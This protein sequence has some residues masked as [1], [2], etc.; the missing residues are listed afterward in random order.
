MKKTKQ[1]FQLDWINL[2]PQVVITLVWIALVAT[3]YQSGTWLTGWDN[4]H[5]EFNFPLNLGRATSA[6]WQEYQGLGLQGG[7]GHASEFVRVLIL[8]LLS[9]IV[10][11]D[12]IR[13]VATLGMV[14]VGGL[15]IDQLMR[16]L[17][18]KQT[19]T[20]QIVASISAALFYM[21]NVGTVQNFYVPFDPF[22]WFFGMLPWLILILLDYLA[23]PNRKKA[24]NLFLVHVLASPLGYVQTV[25]VV[26]LTLVGSI[27]FVHNLRI[28]KKHFFSTLK[29]KAL[30]SMFTVILII[31]ANGFWF[32]PVV[33]FTLTNS[34]V[35]V[36]AKMNQLAT[37]EVFY[38]NKYRGQWSDVLLMK[39]FW[40]DLHDI[41]YQT[42]EFEYILQPW[43][44]HFEKQETLV[45][46]YSIVALAGVGAL[47][48][49]S[50]KLNWSF[51]LI[52]CLLVTI[53]MLKGENPPLGFIVT[54][55]RNDVPL[56][57][58]IF[59]NAFTKWVVVGSM[60]YSLFFGLGLAGV[61]ELLGRIH[62]KVLVP[63]GV[64]VLLL[65][66]GSVLYL[67]KPTF[68][69][70][71]IYPQMRRQIPKEYFDLFT[72]FRSQPKDRRILLMPIKSLWG[73]YFH[74][75]GYRGSGFIW[76]GIEQ[77]IVD[78]T[79][80]VWSSE[81]ETIYEEFNLAIQT[82][83]IESLKR[84]LQKY[85]I[86]YLFFDETMIQHQSDIFSPVFSTPDDMIQELGLQT[87][88]REGKLTVA[89]T[90]PLLGETTFVQTQDATVI[91]NT[92]T[93]H[94]KID[95]VYTS[96]G[97]YVS[98]HSSSSVDF[99]FGA[100][101]K[102]KL[103]DTFAVSYD[104]NQSLLS[105]QLQQPVPAQQNQ[106]IV[107][108]G[109]KDGETYTTLTSLHLDKKTV[110]IE[111]T[112]Y[113]Q[114]VLRNETT[115]IGKPA[116]KQLQLSEAFDNILIYIGGQ[117]VE[118]KQNEQKEL[119][120]SLT[121]GQ[122]FTVRVF[123]RSL[124]LPPN[125]TLKI[126][127]TAVV[128]CWENPNHPQQLEAS[129]SANQVTVRTQNTS[130]CIPLR[131]GEMKKNQ[132][133]YFE[134]EYYTDQM[135]N[136]PGFCLNTEKN[137][138]CINESNLF[139]PPKAT[140]SWQK[141]ADY[142]FAEDNDTYWI[143]LIAQG[144]P[145]DDEVR[146]ISYRN[147]KVQILSL[148]TELELGTDFWT[149][150]NTPTTIPLDSDL[151]GISLPTQATVVN[152]DTNY[153][154]NCDVFKRGTIEKHR[155]D[156]DI[157]YTANDYSSA[158]DTF[159]LNGTAPNNAYLLN[160]NGENSEGR[161]TKLMVSNQANGYPIIESLTSDGH[162]NDWF[163]IPQMNNVPTS[164]AEFLLTF[165]T[166]SFGQKAQSSLHSIS[167]YPVSQ[168]WLNQIMITNDL[169]P[170]VLN[171][172]LPTSVTSK[173]LLTFLYTVKI[174]ADSS[175]TVVSLSQ[176]Y[177]TGWLAFQLQPGQAFWNGKFLEHT[178]YNGWANA[179]MVKPNKGTNNQSTKQL[180]NQATI[181][182]F[183]WPQVLEYVGFGFCVVTWA[184]L[185]V[186][187]RRKSHKY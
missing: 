22:S 78:R 50:K 151:L 89:S 6:V 175:P 115:A 64:L 57:S 170:I 183:Y 4:L 70:Q 140:E 101:S 143:N 167:I 173:K 56:F 47:Y 43:I 187:T 180:S 149:A 104:E 142:F 148:E 118:L 158:C 90:A 136:R 162:F 67:S 24:L 124:T 168:R 8:Y 60:M 28:S 161:K 110:T 48:A 153:F 3:N 20:V 178:K 65:S 181:N 138:R 66:I 61:V 37:P 19:R 63:V 135:A 109:L 32:F 130:G 155:D 121:V 87:V 177:N 98:T 147:P 128:Q 74:D 139:Y 91:T 14:F 17:L 76:Y 125:S 38:S 97:S 72:F 133:L 84:L 15:G 44:T 95:P 154:S 137:L 94:D 114:L 112:E 179:W 46:A 131:A 34:Q 165:E 107:I 40:F 134:V 36:Q 120:L 1:R 156:E 11:A 85:N 62:K 27:L 55:L 31:I 26:Y 182:I 51:E 5:P 69:G 113:A 157:I 164:V 129:S 80:D 116:K 103:N 52:L 169:Q 68:S 93:N 10:P 49:V 176:G 39:G 123:D 35:T 92:S 185:V 141:L 18:K 145:S 117:Y 86:S 21:L 186:S 119:P 132:I 106:S 163:S 111:F 13:Y 9:F 25:F 59:R 75:W 184:V 88:W 7:M 171:Q 127:Q 108:P 73:W 82:K 53:F 33:Y 30:N 172:S 126:D 144:N 16:Y 2:F 160:L 23:Q 122:P 174:P 159:V 99:P 96:L 42:H 54:F 166:R 71:F 77:P 146:T 150:L 83:D 45:I 100:V 105:M 29:Q 12:L 79:F 58:Q 152:I 41:N 81:N 102:E